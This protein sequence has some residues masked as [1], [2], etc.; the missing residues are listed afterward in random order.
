[1]TTA[2]EPRWRV[3]AEVMLRPYA[4]ILFS[5][6]IGVGLLVLAAIACTPRLALAT[7]AAIAIAGLGT[8]LFGLGGRTLREGGIGCIA[9]LTTLALAVFAPGGG[10]PVAL[11]IFAALLSLLFAA[12]F[13]AVFANVALPTHALPFIAAT[14]LVHLAARAMPE[15]GSMAALAE[16]AAWLPRAWLQPSWLDIPAA[17]VFGHGKATGS[18][19]AAALLLHSRIGFLL[20]CVGGLVVAGLRFWLRDPAAWSLMDITAF[21][22]GILAALAIGGVWFVPQPSSLLL[23]A[24]SAGV[25]ALVSYALFP[26]LGTWSLPVISLPFVVTVH[27]VLT[28]ARMRQHDRWPRSTV[29]GDRPEEA[30]A[31]H[32]VRMRRFGNLAWLPF[33]L[34]F[35]GEWFVSQGHDGQHTHQGLW[36]H[37]LDFEGRTPDGKAHTGEGK[38]LR[39]YVCYGLPV[40][41]AGAGTVTLV[42]DGIPDN[43]VGE[44][45]TQDNWGNAVVIQH[46]ANLFSVCAHLLPKSIRVKV[47][48]VVTPGMEIGRCGNSGRSPIP[49]LHFQIQRSRPLGSPT[50]AFDFGDVMVRRGAELEIGT[51]TVPSEGWFVRPVQRDDALARAMSWSPGTQFEL[52]QGGNDRTEIAKVEVD[53]RGK[54]SLRSP[55][56]RLDFDAY[57]NGLVL[58]DY[59]GAAD[60]LLRYL[61]LAFARLPFD[62]SPSLAWTDA[63]SRRLFMPRWRRS[64]ADLWIVLAPEFGKLDVAYSMR[65]EAGAVR[66]E[67][68]AET[69]QSTAVLSLEGKTHTIQIEHGGI[70]TSLLMKRLVPGYGED[71]RA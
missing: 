71:G 49:H 54:R 64:L 39:D 7:L 59:S 38:E 22:N 69:W 20:A 1:M 68:K 63:L 33:R 57:D 26:V 28:A 40:V 31:H 70:R 42:E 47:G 66:V 16:P 53:L 32:L 50:I 23:A 24:V 52:V 60:S 44:I 30:L 10:P 46:G 29:P 35:R 65:R 43:P 4:Q 6:D 51:H 62:P 27:L 58:V 17:L 21:F 13:Q 14:W 45:N 56:A 2:F 3:A 36:R 9:V 67:G 48:D 15:A 19:I 18:L 61:L 37:G 41:A 25:S 5:R 12:S 55:R 8:L 34:P 11:V